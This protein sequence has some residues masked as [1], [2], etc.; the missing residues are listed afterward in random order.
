MGFTPAFLDELRTRVSLVSVVGR[1]VKLIRKGREHHGLCPFHN[2][3]SPSFTVNEDKGFYHCF[4][5][6]AHGDAI[7]FEMRSQNLTFSEAVEKLAAE[8]GLDIP[9]ATPQD[10]QR[11]ARRA[12]LHDAME[13]A[14]RFFEEQLHSAAGREG[15]AYL[16]GR[17]L[18]DDTIARFRLG[19]APD[20]RQAMKTA[21]MSE[22]LP[23]TLLVEAGLLKQPEDG[24]AGGRGAT[25]DMFR[26]RVTYPITDRR[27]RVIAFGA[28]TLGDAQ[29]K[30]LN[31]PETPL[32]HKGSTLYALAQARESARSKGLV[33]AVEGHMDVIALYQA[34]F[35][36]A[37]APLGTALTEDQIGELWK[38]SDEPILCFDGDSAGQ[39]AMSRAAD[40]CLPILRPGKSLRFAVLPAPE[41]PD[42]L[43]KTKGRAA[44]QAVIDQAFPL[45]DQVWN[46]FIAQHQTDTPERRAATERGILDLTD[47][48]AD[49]MVKDLY[50]RELKDRL[51]THLRAARA[52]TRPPRPD[53]THASTIRGG[54]FGRAVT[55]AQALRG[56]DGRL[57]GAGRPQPPQAV[58]AR[59]RQELMLLCLVICHPILLAQ[60]ADR[61][62]EMAFQDSELD[63]VRRGIL[64]HVIAAQGFDSGQMESCLQSE[65]LEAAVLRLKSS[66]FYRIVQTKTAFDAGAVWENVFTLYT[67]ESLETDAGRAIER[68]AFDMSEANFT[69]LAAM[70]PSRMRSLDFEDDG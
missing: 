19:W 39:R 58:G 7:G 3:K 17:G 23:E 30:Y 48:I 25:F 10:R 11:E 14:C 70:A 36:Y 2:E 50:R 1:R 56:L 15:L 16:K 32:F 42:S 63:K 37:V 65:G 27:G 41:D 35:D 40:R 21:L 46:H 18:T 6:G 20:G 24:A 43:I 51:Y 59:A 66:D 28:R 55:G 53:M 57:P 31:S 12:S 49:G 34:G 38:L 22:T 29:P 45:V 26:T 68:L 62:G 5:C 60:V 44:M 9:Q 69:R 64:K 13:A 8:A 67:R 52:Q 4:G 61:L 54:R 33:L 47:P